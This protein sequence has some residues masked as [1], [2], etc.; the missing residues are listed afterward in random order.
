MTYEG[1]GVTVGDGVGVAVGVPVGVGDGIGVVCKRLILG[2][3]GPLDVHKI[4]PDKLNVLG[5]DVI[6]RR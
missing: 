1:M 5:A 4:N 2:K 3:M 6:I